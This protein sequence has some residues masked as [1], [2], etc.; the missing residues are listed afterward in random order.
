MTTVLDLSRAHRL[1]SRQTLRQAL[2]CCSPVAAACAVSKSRRRISAPG[3]GSGR[4]APVRRYRLGSPG[5][6][7]YGRLPPPAAERPTVPY[8]DVQAFRSRVHGGRDSCGTRA[9]DGDVEELVCARRVEH[10][11]AAGSASSEGLSSTDPSGTP[12]HVGE[13]PRRIAREAA[14]CVAILRSVE[15]LCGPSL[16]VRS[17]ASQQLRS[18]GRPIS[19]GPLCAGLDE[20]DPAQDHRAD[21][22]LAKSAS[23]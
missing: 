7:R 5:S 16:R 2:L 14:A 23:A 9:H 3:E 17:S 13:G 20:R 22:A 8:D 4:R 11:E 19:T 18:C 12:R 6:F 1:A 10:S 21:D 15:D